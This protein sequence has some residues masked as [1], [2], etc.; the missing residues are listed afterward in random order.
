MWRNDAV[1]FGMTRAVAWRLATPIIAGGRLGEPRRQGRWQDRRQDGARQPS[2]RNA[3]RL[4]HQRGA[5]KTTGA[6]STSAPPSTFFAAGH[7]AAKSAAVGTRRR[8]CRRSSRGYKLQTVVLRLCRDGGQ[9]SV[10]GAPLS[11]V[12]DR[13][14]RLR[15]ENIAVGLGA[16]RHGVPSGGDAHGGEGPNLEV[17]STS[18]WRMS[19]LVVSSY[20]S[21]CRGD[22]GPDTPSWRNH[23]VLA[24]DAA[25]ASPPRSRADLEAGDAAA[26]AAGCWRRK[27]E[28]K[29]GRAP[30]VSD[31]TAGRSMTGQGGAAL[32]RSAVRLG[33]KAEGSGGLQRGA[34]R[35]AELRTQRHEVVH[36]SFV[37][38]DSFPPN[39]R[40]ERRKRIFWKVYFPTLQTYLRC[41]KQF[42][43]R[44]SARLPERRLDPRIFSS[45]WLS[46]R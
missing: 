40:E 22:G 30:A 38:E 1:Q 34:Q 10:A 25:H 3:V 28:G 12:P 26:L 18:S 11:P 14:G 7:P 43:R 16:R 29:V 23:V 5:R 41:V 27:G 21:G 37:T 32:Y 20:A 8:V 6:R 42:P 9:G 2:R 46:G 13:E 31:K 15:R 39:C 17:L 19:S 35:T 45:P 44:V 4:G 36:S 33:A 24:G